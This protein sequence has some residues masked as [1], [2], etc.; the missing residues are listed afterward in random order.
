MD[1]PKPTP[2]P[3]SSRERYRKFVE[4][5][6][7]RRLDD[8]ADG[9]P[10]SA[11]AV[12]GAA[13]APG[14]PAATPSARDAV[15]PELKKQRR[16]KRRAY[17]REYLR[18]LKPHRLAITAVFLFALLVAG[19]QM[20][21]PLFMR[22]IIDKVLLNKA[23]D[24]AGRIARLNLAG[25][26]FLAVLSGSPSSPYLP[27]RSTKAHSDSGTSIRARC[28]SKQSL[29]S[30]FSAFTT[31]PYVVE[32]AVGDREERSVLQDLVFVD[33]AVGPFR[34]VGDMHGSFLLT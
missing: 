12:A 19:F 10:K 29:S 13:G 15:T 25:A 18:W 21:E 23:L 14:I 27:R 1:T 24:T 6:R 20:I 7:Q 17:L 9:E 26:T 32:L 16:G 30:C 11:R 22:Y 8:I 33:P 5:Y 2:Q 4:D 34:E 31:L 28:L 3:R